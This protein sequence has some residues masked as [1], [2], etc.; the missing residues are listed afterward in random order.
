MKNLLLIAHTPS[1]NTRKLIQAVL[2]NVSEQVDDLKIIPFNPF[3]ATSA[4]VL[5]ADGILLFT[6][7]NFGYMSGAL[8]DFF[9]RTY[10]DLIDRKGG[11]PYSLI[12][13]AGND[14]TGTVR[15]VK[16]ICTG[17]SWQ[18]VQEPLVLKG[19]YQEEFELQIQEYSL[20]FAIGLETGI[21]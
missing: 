16:S 9:D 3:D 4:H 5:N 2:R 14:G 10:Y 18:A 8:K 13:R 20:T 17:L 6:T 12:V 7:E 19:N 1:N 15:S 11:L 21:Y